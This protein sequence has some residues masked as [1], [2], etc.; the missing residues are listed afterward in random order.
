MLSDP[1]S[2]Q[3]IISML[4]TDGR[5]LPKP[6]APALGNTIAQLRRMNSVVSDVSSTTTAATNGVNDRIADSPTL[7]SHFSGQPSVAPPR[8]MMP[9]PGANGKRHYFN[10]GG[11]RRPETRRRGNDADGGLA[12]LR[13]SVEL[14][15]AAQSSPRSPGIVR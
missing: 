13:R 8:P 12:G 14:S 5:A 11:G 7:P 9:R 2:E 10:I 6:P 15:S 3:E 4:M 1:Y